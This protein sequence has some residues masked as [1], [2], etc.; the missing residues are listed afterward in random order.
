MPGDNG[1]AFVL[2]PRLDPGHASM[3]TEILQRSARIKVM[4]AKDWMLLAPNNVYVIP[5]NRDMTIFLMLALF[6]DDFVESLK[7]R[8]ALKNAVQKKA[9]MILANPIAIGEPLKANLRGY[10]SAPA[11]KNLLIIY[12][13]C[14][15]CRRK[16]DDKIVRCHDCSNYDDETVKFVEI[17]PRVKF[18]KNDRIARNSSNHNPQ[19]SRNRDFE[20]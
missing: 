2:I 6:S 12:L 3:L 7:K 14:L 13:Y 16:G 17:G 19:I 18:T 15:I 4:E 1:M 9:D 11:K 10:Y 8:A 20:K 5:H